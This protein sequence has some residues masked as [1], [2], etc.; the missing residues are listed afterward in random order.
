M[1]II[2]AAM[3]TDRIIGSG[4]GMPWHVPSE[5]QQYLEQVSG[6]SIIMGRKSFE[7][8]GPDLRGTGTELFVL[9]RTQAEISGRTGYRSLEEAIAAAEREGVGLNER[10][11]VSISLNSAAT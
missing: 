3:S 1:I 9:S 5:Y 6:Q 8:F 7:I 2:I 11:E 4:D 10:A